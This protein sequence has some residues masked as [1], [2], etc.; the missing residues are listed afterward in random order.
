MKTKYI[1]LVILLSGMLLLTGCWDNTELNEKHVVLD[2]AV[3]KNTK[4][5]EVEDLSEAKGYTVT[6]SIPDIAKLSGG[7]SL[8]E[9]VKTVLSVDSATIS[10]SVDQIEALT[11]NTI[12]FS[13]TKALLLGEELMKDKRLFKMALNSF[14][15]N[16]EV[17]RS[18]YLLAVEGKASE[19][20]KAQSYQ[21]PIIGLYI[22]KFFNNGE[23]AVGD[24]EPQYL[25]EFYKEMNET[26][27]SMMPILRENKDEATLEITGAAVIKDYEL[28]D[29][30]EA[31]DVRAKLFLEGKIKDIPIII[32][33]NGE[34]YMFQIE[35]EK[36]KIDYKE[37]QEQL[38]INIELEVF[39][40]LT[41]YMPSNLIKDNGAYISGKIEEKVN[42][43]LKQEI[44]NGMMK[45]RRMNTDYLHLGQD[46]YRR[47]PE[48]WE[49]YKEAW[50]QSIYSGAHINVSVHTIVQGV[51]MM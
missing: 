44:E 13:H 42:D 38:Y 16:L 29:Y 5:T 26:G 17:G 48:L 7:D 32:D 39:G 8:A 41:E 35:K 37:E 9:D 12:S 2:V 14:M 50:R 31:E 19:L 28:V 25:G 51:G 33:E 3:D 40:E 11:Q 27:I 22:T 15:E 24:S 47:K 18:T 20:S 43:K 6:Y 34:Y 10:E 23:R 21:N 45:A 4:D 30:I 36:S 49:R 1:S 46:L